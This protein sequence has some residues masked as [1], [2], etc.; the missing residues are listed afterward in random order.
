MWTFNV[1]PPLRLH[2]QFKMFAST[3]SRSLRTTPAARLSQVA[4]Q[5]QPQ[6]QQ[7]RMA[8][9]GTTFKL[10]NGKQIPAIGFGTWQDK[11]AQEP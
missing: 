6:S 1:W 11:D 3:A 10:N 4:R 7:S 9:N 2:H 8:H 5:I